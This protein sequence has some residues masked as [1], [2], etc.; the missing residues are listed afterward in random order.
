MKLLVTL[1][2]LP[3]VADDILIGVDDEKQYDAILK[4]VLDRTHYIGV[5]FNFNKV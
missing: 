2:F 5:R 3:S 4:K 1:K